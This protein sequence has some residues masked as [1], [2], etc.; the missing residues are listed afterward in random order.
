M[1]SDLVKRVVNKLGELNINLSSDFYIKDGVLYGSLDVPAGIITQLD[2]IK[3]DAE[4]HLLAIDGINE[5]KLSFSYSPPKRS[6]KKSK[7]ESYNSE[8]K[9]TPIPPV[10]LSN[11]TTPSIA[12][13][14]IVVA[15]GKGGVGKSTTAVNIAKFLS[16]Q[17]Y[18]VGILDLDVYGP[19][20]PKLMGV[21]GIKP[22]SQ[23]TANGKRLITTVVK[24]NIQIMSIGFFIDNESA[25]IWR[26][27]MSSSFVRQMVT[28]VSWVDLDFLIVDLPPGT[29]DIQ[30][31]LSK[32]V[33]VKGAVIVSIPNDLAIL[34]VK[35]CID[36]FAK[37][38]VPILG[39]V[40]NMSY[41]KNNGT[42]HYIFGSNNIA[43]DLKKY[44]IEIL[45]QIPLDP[46][47]A[48]GDVEN[49]I[50]M[51]YSNIVSSILKKVGM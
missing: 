51:E 4:R 44:G 36:M 8:D 23:V 30:I 34:D 21:E 37:V 3:S 19:S 29:G 40:E 2:K 24:D 14:I 39:C 16:K 17:K 33:D 11:I 12:S 35:R 5:A 20:V 13:N 46:I 7:Q 42:K 43:L 41:Y 1:D 50:A 26:G 18:H 28:D 32:L 22:E 6:I 25:V 31:T 38:N 15:S 48:K 49:N 9:S 27:S 45:G 10:A 47:I